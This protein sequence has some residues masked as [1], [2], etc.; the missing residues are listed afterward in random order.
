MWGTCVFWPSGTLHIS[1]IVP[2]GYIG[3]SSCEIFGSSGID[4]LAY[5]S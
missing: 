5:I 1:D 4:W 2:I 3:G